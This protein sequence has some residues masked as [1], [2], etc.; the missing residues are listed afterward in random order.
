MSKFGQIQMSNLIWCMLVLSSQSEPTMDKMRMIAM[1]LC[2]TS[3][4]KT[5]QAVPEGN[6]R[7]VTAAAQLDLG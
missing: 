2:E 5:I 4:L 3:R 7:A 1:S 6:L